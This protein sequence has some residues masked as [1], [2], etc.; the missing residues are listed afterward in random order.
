MLR[1]SLRRSLARC[2]LALWLASA[3][4]FAAAA[5]CHQSAADTASTVPGD[6]YGACDYLEALGCS[7]SC[8]EQSLK[9]QRD[10]ALLVEQWT[11]LRISEAPGWRRPAR[12]PGPQ[13]ELLARRSYPQVCTLK[14]SYLK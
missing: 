10:G 13:P 12:P 1:S 14:C 5:I 11:R 8:N 2:F 7:P 9:R 6:E 3:S 4:V